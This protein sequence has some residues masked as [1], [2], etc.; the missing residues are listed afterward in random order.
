MRRFR[1][2]FICLAS[3][4]LILPTVSAARPLSSLSPAPAITLRWRVDDGAIATGVEQRG[5][6]WGPHI[7][8][9]GPE[10]YAESP[11]QQRAVW[12]L[13]KARMEITQPGL[14][15]ASTWF[16]TSGLLVRELMSGQIQTGDR[17]FEPRQPAD[18]PIAGDLDVALDQTITY[19]DLQ[20]L[21]SLNHDKRVPSRIED[22][23]VVVE[24]LGKGGFVRQDERLLHYNVQLTTYDDVLG[25]NLPDVFTAALAPDRLLFI[26]GRPLTE[27]YWTTVPIAGAPT[28]VLIQ[29]FERRVLTYTPSNPPGWQVEWGNVGRQYAQWR[30]GTPEDGALIDPSIVV[31]PSTTD[32]EPA[33]TSE[34]AIRRLEV[35]SPEAA[36]IAQ[37]RDGQVAA[38]VLDM[39]SGVLYSISGTRAFP[40][41]STVKVPIMLGLLNQV[42]QQNRAVAEWEDRLLRAMIQRSDND[43]ASTLLERIGGAKQLERYLQSIGLQHTRID[44]STWGTSTTT[45]QDMVRLLAKLGDCTILNDKLCHYALE[46]MRDV[47]PGQRWGVSAGVPGSRSVALKNGWY[48]E[49]GAWTI[50]S[51]GYVKTSQKRYAVAIYTRQN[52]TMRYGVDTIESIAAEVYPAVP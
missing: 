37:K 17:S 19:G 22:G 9:S 12:Y 24:V 35:L 1:L 48:P 6:T 51:I 26:A 15:P 39:Q 4:L 20:P 43:A 46:L 5:W 11:L 44:R 25:H 8:R 32:T 28:D 42:Q 18:L 49:D 2:L 36:R 40:M 30:Y 10:P 27:P 50:N 41:Y 16:V 3:L 34:S 23:A 33:D 45:A 47:I 7:F 52:A 31:E 29:A 21:A 13:D 14:D 38:A